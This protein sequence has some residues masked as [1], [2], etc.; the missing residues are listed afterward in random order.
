MPRRKL[1][2]S[3]EPQTCLSEVSK[4]VCSFQLMAKSQ[5]SRRT[6]ALKTRWA[7]VLFYEAS[8][9]I[10]KLVFPFEVR[11]F[12]ELFIMTDE[13]KLPEILQEIQQDIKKAM[14]GARGLSSE[15]VLYKTFPAFNKF[16]QMEG[17]SIA[18]M[19]VVYCYVS[20]S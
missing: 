4:R 6:L 9:R 8:F 13:K 20:I 2:E 1:V 16:I 19:L 7:F 18:S 15:M 10:E 3:S 5:I 11:T 14:S 12:K 17:N